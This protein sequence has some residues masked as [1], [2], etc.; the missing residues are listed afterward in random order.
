MVEPIAEHRLS[1]LFGF[2]VG[3]IGFPLW[4]VCKFPILVCALEGLDKRYRECMGVLVIC[5][6][7]LRSQ[8]DVCYPLFELVWQCATHARRVCR[9][10]S[11]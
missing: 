6:E 10:A 3:F 2:V 5:L 7:Q 4:E 1:W 9:I 8:V 11:S